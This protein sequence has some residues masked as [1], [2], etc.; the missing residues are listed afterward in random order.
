VNRNPEGIK[1]EPIGCSDKQKD[2]TDENSQ[3][4]V[5][6]S[7]MDMFYRNKNK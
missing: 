6:S 7:L 3:T 1:A 4:G 5:S 2:P